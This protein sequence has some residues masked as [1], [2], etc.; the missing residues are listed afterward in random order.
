VKPRERERVWRGVATGEAKIVVGARSALFLPWARLGLVVVD[1]EH[2]Q[3]YKQEDGVPYHAR[4]MAVVYASLAK[5]PAVL[6]SAT[7]SLETLVNAQKGRYAHVRLQDR[8]GRAELPKTSLID[9][10]IAKLERGMWL[11]DPLA[12]AVGATLAAGDQALLFL[13]RRG[14]APLTLCR[15]CGHRLQCPHCSAAMIEHRF[16]RQMLCHFCGHTEPVLEACPQCHTQGKL[17]PCGPGIER[18]AE[19]AR[20]RFPEARLAILS[21]DLTSGMALRGALAAIAKGEVNLVV[22]TQ[23]V[24]KGHN[25][26]HLTLV[27]VVDADLALETGDPR[28]GERT[29]AVIAQVAGR[30]GRG[31][32][33]GTALVQTYLPEHP[34]MASLVS[35]DRD[36]YFAKE[37][38]IRASAG[39]PPYRRLAAIVVSGT[40]GLATERLAKSLRAR[41][42]VAQ[43]IEVLGPAP[44][45]IHLLRGRHR[46]RLLVK[47]DPAIN[48]QAFLKAWLAGTRPKGSLRIDVDVDPYSFL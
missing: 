15:A 22:G 20:Q 18:V 32:R 23:L 9:M 1:E 6:S 5:C 45:P 37:L 30:A 19:E 44:A 48:L 27:G 38:A 34:L 40:D 11:S 31:A 12:E 26:P 16:R 25:F 21:S 14:Y 3:A 7:P 39:L 33:G 43:G 36:G 24:A 17:V 47:S 42:P 13:N 29:W 28:G 4:D 35:G 8:H 10:R 41:A 46:W 2:E